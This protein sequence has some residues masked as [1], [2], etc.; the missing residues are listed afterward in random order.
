MIG[1][2]LSHYRILERLGE[3]GMGVVYKAR[4][5]HLDRVVAIKL[6]P[7]DKVAEPERRRRF[8]REAKAASSLAHPNIVVIHDIAEEQGVHFLVM[9]YVAGKTLGE[10]ITSTGL[11]SAQVLSC[12]SQIAD[13]LAK[14]HAAGIVHRDLKPG[15]VIVDDE[16]RVK[17][18]DFGLAKLTEPSPVDSATTATSPALT[19]EGRIV[20]TVAYMSPE[21]VEGKRLDGR[22]DIFVF[23]A[24]VYEMLTGRKAFQRQSSLSSLAA[25]S[26][27]EPPPTEGVPSE[28]VALVGRCLQRSPD[29]R[30][31][32]AR[33]LKIALEG[34]RGTTSPPQARG[35]TAGLPAIAVLPFTD[36]SAQKDQE[37]FCDGIAEEIIDAL[38]HIREL[39]VVARTSAF[40]FKGRDLDIRE[41]GRVLNVDV[42]L[43]GS[44]RKAGDRLRISAQLVSVADGYHLWS[45]RFD[46]RMEDVF[47]IQDEIALAIADRFKIELLGDDREKVLKRRT[48]DPEA[49]SS[50]LK[51]R[52]LLA[53]WSPDGVEKGLAY[54]QEAIDRD[55]GFTSSYLGI[56]ETF[57]HMGIL[58]A[59]SPRDVF[60]RAKQWLARAQ[61]V[62]PA[63]REA[64]FVSALISFWFEWDWPT[65]ELEFKRAISHNPGHAA[66]RL[67]Y[68]WHL[69]AIRRFEEAREEI[70]RAGSLDPIMPL[71]QGSSVGIHVYAGEY[72]RAEAQ[73]D[74]AIE[75][76][77]DNGLAC[78]H[79]GAAYRIQGKP[80]K[81]MELFRRAIELGTGAAWAESSLAV[82]H[83]IIGNRSQA[84]L[85]LQ[86]LLDRR[87]HE[88]ISALC[89][90]AIFSALG[91][92][93]QVF[94]WLD[95]AVRE[96]DSVLSLI[97]ILRL[98]DDV[99]DDPRYRALLGRLKLA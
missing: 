45:E 49:Y 27:A 99:E 76:A 62:D 73:F 89:L 98:F 39:R 10:L 37:Y 70:R 21:Q 33:E 77:P 40:A 46:R 97:N 86:Q 60:E 51:A 34:V 85:I 47:A 19:G 4:D 88:Y 43:E 17:L 14:A 3:G 28:W 29:D 67:W 15:N 87:A 30:F 12:A 54:F 66:A 32:D 58:S 9:E 57:A 96:R 53:R 24:V 83:V 13:A 75:I 59:A 48:R 5:T 61:A 22:S 50:Y 56:A 95:T 23:G 93:E 72:E 8:V 74:K 92:K 38:T 35:E 26:R 52:H 44:V 20:G 82:A 71:V 1:R 55:P 81:A 69:T 90:A 91:D 18:L 42:L 7:P 64:D 6:L 79:M 2:T 36:M 63:D 65:A 78:F 80:E 41:I 31:Q 16:G 68:A 84:E 94:E 11:P 25:I